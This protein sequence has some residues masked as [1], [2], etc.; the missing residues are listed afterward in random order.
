MEFRAVLHQYLVCV[1]LL[2]HVQLCDFKD[3]SPPGST[4]EFAWISQARILEWVAVSFSRG[5]SL[6]RD[7]TYILL[8]WQA[9]SLPMSHVGSYWEY[10]KLQKLWVHLFSVSGWF[11]L[12]VHGPCTDYQPGIDLSM[13]KWGKFFIEFL[14]LAFSLI[15]ILYKYKGSL[16]FPWTQC[17]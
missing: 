14:F 2:S 4:Q 15:F 13:E 1:C 9:D 10:F 3:C 6:S 7:W 8:H 12:T 11:L 5:S 16:A 17:I